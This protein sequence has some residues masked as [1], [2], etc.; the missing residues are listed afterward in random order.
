[1]LKFSTA[2][3]STGAKPGV[4]RPSVPFLFNL[5]DFLPAREYALLREKNATMQ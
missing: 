4:D 2:V 5:A 3:D 1:M